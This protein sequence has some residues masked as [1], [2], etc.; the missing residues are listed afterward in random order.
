MNL[1][2][3][4]ELILLWM[5]LVG[6]NIFIRFALR[7]FLINI[8]KFNSNKKRIVIYGA[9]SAAVLLASNL[10]ESKGYI[11]KCFVDDN[12]NLWGKIN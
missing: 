8:L 11:I 5:T 3:P 2:L 4:R 9:G 12:K 10:I 7:D 1:I 6:L